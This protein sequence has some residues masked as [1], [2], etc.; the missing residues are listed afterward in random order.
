MKWKSE[1]QKRAYYRK[2]N[3]EHRDRKRVWM[4]NKRHGTDMPL[5]EGSG[6]KKWKELNRQ[7]REWRKSKVKIT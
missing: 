6:N 7:D 1:E 5:P 2:W 4:W 3:A